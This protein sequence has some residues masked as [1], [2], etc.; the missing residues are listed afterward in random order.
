M[1]HQGGKSETPP[2]RKWCGL[3]CSSF[4]ERAAWDKWQIATAASLRLFANLPDRRLEIKSD[5]SAKT[6][7]WDFMGVKIEW[8]WCGIFLNMEKSQCDWISCSSD[9]AETFSFY[10][11]CIRS[12]VIRHHS[13]VFVSRANLRFLLSPKMI[14]CLVHQI[15]INTISIQEERDLHKIRTQASFWL[16]GQSICGHFSFRGTIKVK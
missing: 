15:E 7:I 13:L 14:E 10:S 8:R 5:N 16:L 12:F 1:Y 9:G 6:W 11:L 4:C 2:W 3:T